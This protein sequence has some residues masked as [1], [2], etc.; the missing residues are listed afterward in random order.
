[1]LIRLSTSVPSLPPMIVTLYHVGTVT[2]GN[3]EYL[4]R[5][6]HLYNREEVFVL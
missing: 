4:K 6:E 1:V 3:A 5:V 2:A